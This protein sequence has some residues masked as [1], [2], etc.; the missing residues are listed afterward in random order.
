MGRR[1]SGSIA[2]RATEFDVTALEAGVWVETITEGGRRFVTAWRKEE[3]E[4]TRHHQ[5][6]RGERYYWVGKLLSHR[7]A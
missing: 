3:E 6:K 1:N 5:E 7:E 2:D 4:A